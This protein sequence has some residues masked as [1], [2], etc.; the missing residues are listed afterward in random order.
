MSEL[1]QLIDRIQWSEFIERLPPGKG[2]LLAGVHLGP[3]LVAVDVLMRSNLPGKIVT[4]NIEFGYCLKTPNV[5]PDHKN[6]KRILLSLMQSLHNG[7]TVYLAAEGQ[8]GSRFRSYELRGRTINLSLGPATLA[9]YAKVRTHWYAALWRDG[10]II[11]E[12]REGPI[13]NQDEPL[14]HWHERWFAFYSNCL[15]EA[16]FSGPE[17]LYRNLNLWREAGS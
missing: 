16:M 5:I 12:L 14:D 2:S 8:Q 6:T 3:P 9:Y 10:K 11:L 15:S 17:N 13:P 1:D 4:S 7:E